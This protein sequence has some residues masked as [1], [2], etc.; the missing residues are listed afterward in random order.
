MYRGDGPPLLPHV[1]D[2]FDFRMIR[3]TQRRTPTLA[4][5]AYPAPDRATLSHVQPPIR[6]LDTVAPEGA[7]QAAQEFVGSDDF[8]GGGAPLDVPLRAMDNWLTQRGNRAEPAE[9]VAALPAPPEILVTDPAWP[10]ARAALGDSLIA[11]ILAG[12]T[13]P[14][15]RSELTRLILVAALVEDLAVTPSPVRTADDVFV[16]LR[17]KTVLLPKAM[18]D[19]IPSRARLVRRHG[20]SEHIVV[21]EEW[22]AYRLGELAHVENALAGEQRERRVTRATESEASQTSDIESSSVEENSTDS[23]DRFQLTDHASRDSALAVQA[24]GQVDVSTHYPSVKVDASVGGSFD[25]SK[26]EAREVATELAKETVARAAKRVESRTRTSRT[27][28][29]LTR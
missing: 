26:S 5:S 19:L 2:V 4:V 1:S 27:T 29:S 28:R 10:R 22:H 8:V 21:R 3:G 14:Q 17:W 11:A 13:S 24:D 25:Y 9:I 20:W 12:T 18:L 7:E 6:F 23:T 16:R 15:A